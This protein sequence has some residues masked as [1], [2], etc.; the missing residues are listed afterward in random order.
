[1]RIAGISSNRGDGC[2]TTIAFDWSLAALSDPNF[3]MPL[4][5]TLAFSETMDITEQ[6]SGG[7]KHYSLS[8]G[9]LPEVSQ[10]EA[11]VTEVKSDK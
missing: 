3:D 1:M 2:Q 10:K 5:G 8:F 11:S 6:R 7:L 9:D 4:Q